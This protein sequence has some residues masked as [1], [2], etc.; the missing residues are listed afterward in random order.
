MESWKLKP[1][2]AYQTKI[3]IWV[4]I[5]AILMLAMFIPMGWGIG[6]EVNG[7]EGVR[8][9][10]LIAIGSNLLWILPLWIWV[11]PY[12]RSL[13]Y[14]IED[15]EVIVRGGVLTKTIKHVPYRT[16]TNIEITRGLI[17]RALGIGSLKIQ[18]AG[19]SGST[20]A[21]EHLAGLANVDEV[22]DRVVT[23]LRKFRSAMAPDQASLLQGS[24]PAAPSSDRLLGEILDELKMI[25]AKLDN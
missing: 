19:M 24:A 11:A 2:K 8:N 7:A 12:R 1:E 9:G 17:D 13:Q 21:E 23:N 14:E 5:S 22:Y 25:R 18:T 16:V 10:I 3:Y 4:I 6:K 15:D 20:G